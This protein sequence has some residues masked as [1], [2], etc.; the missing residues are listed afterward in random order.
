MPIKNSPAPKRKEF[1]EVQKQNKQYYSIVK[2]SNAIIQKARYSFSLQQ[3]KILC[4][5]IT[6]LSDTDTHETEKKF[7]IK[8]FYDFMEVDSKIMTEF[9]KI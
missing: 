4:Y 2:K 9:V 3:Q 7:D 8:T 6:N 1:L 5:L